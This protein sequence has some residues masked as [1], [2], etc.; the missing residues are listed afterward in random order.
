[1]GKVNVLSLG[2]QYAQMILRL[3][4]AVF[5]IVFAAS[6]I[7]GQEKAFEE[8]EVAFEAGQLDESFILFTKAL[9]AYQ[10]TANDTA[11]AGCYDRLATIKLHQGETSE[12]LDLLEKGLDHARKGVYSDAFLRLL[13]FKAEFY[14]MKG[15]REIGKACWRE[16]EPVF[17]PVGN[18]S[19]SAYRNFGSIY[20]FD[21]SDTSD[22]LLQKAL[23]LAFEIDNKAI[24][25]GIYR[26][27]CRRREIQSDLVGSIQYAIEG[28]KYLNDP[29][30]SMAANLYLSLAE[31]FDQLGDGKKARN[32]AES[33]VA[34]LEGSRYKTLYH[35]AKSVLGNI[36]AEAND[37]A[38]AEN[39][40]SE[41]M[42]YFSEKNDLRNQVL[43]YTQQLEYYRSIDAM[44]V[45]EKKYAIL[46]EMENILDDAVVDNNIHSGFTKFFFEIG[47]LRNAK[48]YLAAWK[49]SDKKIENGYS[50]ANIYKYTGLIAEAENDYNRGIINLNK[51]KKFQDSLDLQKRRDIIYL[52]EA[53]YKQ[54]EKEKEIQALDGQNQIQAASLQQRNRF[55]GLGTLFLLI[56]SGLCW[57]LYRR[58][59]KFNL[60][61]DQIQKNLSE[62]EILLDEIHSRVK[63]SLQTISSILSLQ[64]RS[65]ENEKAIEAIVEG[66]NR[67]ISMSL[68]H[69]NLYVKNNTSQINLADYFNQLLDSLF[70]SYNIS[71]G[72]IKLEKNFME[73]FLNV[74]Q[75]I[76]IGL[77]LNELVSNA[78]KHAFKGR[79][80]G[81]L[82]VAF[83]QNHGD[84]QLSVT[85]DGVGFGTSSSGNHSG[86]G[87]RIIQAFSKKLNATVSRIE[88]HGTSVVVSF[89][90]KKENHPKV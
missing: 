56:L 3:I 10:T 35:V 63:N 59:N 73:G 12:S 53:E 52:L 26:T 29:K 51:Y 57:M 4:T 67:V 15:D 68:I 65:M 45:A 14:K 75:V 43:S 48:K 60:Q 64:S 22:V 17:K 19:I 72:K 6:A 34:S 85:D 1:M 69:E 71:K 31:S 32:Y 86:F 78:L 11:I 88:G 82:K 46:K 41:A 83:Q 25:P 90:L 70:T 16:L 30:S 21:P 13:M 37:R 20:Q 40:W 38:C 87:S 27:L 89:A 66:K 33:A 79:E 77:I 61:K 36:C 62:K 23:D 58:N 42:V 2:V 54:A 47:D 9:E 76:P 80:N 50:K 39:N 24:L 74:D 28:L 84:Y 44:D 55:L 8:G 5:I 7:V 49:G 81:I 18:R